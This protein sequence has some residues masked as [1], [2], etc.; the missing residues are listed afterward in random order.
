LLAVFQ[1]LEQDEQTR[2]VVL[3]GGGER[4]FVAGSDV[5][6][7]G[8]LD[9]NSARERSRVARK[10]FESIRSAP[11]PV[12]AAVKGYALGAGLVMAA[13]ADIIIAARQASFGL[14]EI[15]VGVMG[16]TKHLARIVPEKVMRWMALTGNRVDAA[17][18][19]RLGVVQ[20]VVEIDQVMPAA[21]AVAAQISEKSPA[22]MRLMKEVINLTEPMELTAGYHVETYATSIISAHPH[23]KE[24]ARA[25]K[26][27]RKAVY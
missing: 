13:Q 6:E 16:G 4:A 2:C 10:V 18:L 14:P 5:G 17:Y 3:T 25:F 9:P 26:E 12:I 23:S 22:G 8:E 15:N 27:K 7:L 11:V 20:Q 21:L 1:A 24:A 19:E